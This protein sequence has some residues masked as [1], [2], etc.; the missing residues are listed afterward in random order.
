MTK[1]EIK[2]CPN[3]LCQST[4]TN[5]HLDTDTKWYSVKC[6]ICDCQWGFD[7]DLDRAIDKW[8][9]RPSP[10]ISVEDELPKNEK[11]VLIKYDAGR[12][13]K[14]KFFVGEY[15]PIEKR[16]RNV[17]DDITITHW[18]EIPELPE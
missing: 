3:V 11:R 18:M 1:P 12:H 2:P 8:N 13:I 7:N 9:T 5:V 17:L 16:W 14:G 4:H 6:M 10:L 15:L